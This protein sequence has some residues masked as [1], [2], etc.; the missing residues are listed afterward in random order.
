MAAGPPANHFTHRSVVNKIKTAGLPAKN[1]W[2]PGGDE[3][4]LVC[5]HSLRRGCADGGIAHAVSSGFH[6][7]LQ[8]PRKASIGI[9][10][11]GEIVPAERFVQKANKVSAVVWVQQARVHLDV[12]LGC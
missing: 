5:V 3:T 9:D 8:L 2:R 11:Y 10:G 12:R 4:A 1:H 6:M 7:S